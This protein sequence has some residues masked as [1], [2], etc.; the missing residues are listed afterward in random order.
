MKNLILIRHA[1][2]E[3]ALVHQ[4]DF[5][6]PLSNRGNAQAKIQAQLMGTIHFRTVLHSAALRT[7]QTAQQLLQEHMHLELISRKDMYNADL[8]ELIQILIE[9][10]SMDNLILVGH[11]PGISHLFEH[12]SGQWEPFETCT[13]AILSFPENL[14]HIHMLRSAQVVQI[15]H[16]EI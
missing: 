15:Q 16:P 2:A 5:D 13:F 6:R 14:N 1:Q 7:T 12:L 8:D 4:K 9:N 11:N 3:D 10:W